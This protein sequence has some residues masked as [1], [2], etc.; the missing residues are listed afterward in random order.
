MSSD[1]GLLRVSGGDAGATIAPTAV[2]HRR[3]NRADAG[4][5]CVH[6]GHGCS[7]AII[8]SG[9]LSLVNYTVSDTSKSLSLD[10]ISEDFLP[11]AG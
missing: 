7:M 3:Q 11:L 1:R 5:A 9:S 6:R 10:I 4:N 8:F 2:P